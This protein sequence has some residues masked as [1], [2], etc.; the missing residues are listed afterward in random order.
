MDDPKAVYLTKEKFAVHADGVADDTEAIQKAIDQLQGEGI[1]FVPEGR[2][3]LTKTLTVWP[4]VRLI[5]YGTARP[6]FVL[7]ENTPGYQDPD[8]SSTWS[9]SPAGGAGAGAAE[10]PGMRAPGPSTPA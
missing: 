10:R 9:F 3:R 4:A 6:V 8:T 1:V 5:G 2:Y 7:G